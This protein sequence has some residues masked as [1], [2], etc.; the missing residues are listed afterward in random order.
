M[1]YSKLAV[2]L[3]LLFFLV[4]PS[5]LPAYAQEAPEG[6]ITLCYHDVQP[7]E[8]NQDSLDA[9][10][11]TVKELS[12][13]FEWLKNNGY[14]S[15][16]IDDILAA[17][18][19]EKALPKKS[20]LLS[21]D[22]GY[23]SFYELVFPMLKAY[24]FKSLLALQTGWLSTP[25]GK[26]VQYGEKGKMPREHF[27]TWAQIKE[28]ADSG[29]VEIASHS[30]RLHQGHLSTPQG[31]KQPAGASRKYDPKT[32]QYESIAEFK[33]RIKNDL[34]QSSA[35]IQQ[36]TGYKPR[37]IVWPYGHYT[38]AGSQAAKEAGF[39]I[40]ASLSVPSDDTTI[41]RFLIYSG[42]NL[43]EVID[44]MEKGLEWGHSGRKG[45]TFQ[46]N[47]K[48][49]FSPRYRLQRVV[50]VD[51]DM[52][53]DPDPQQQYNNIS[54]LF[55]R[56]KASGCNVVYLQAY[57]DPDGD[58]VAD[59]LYFPNRH[60]PMRADLFN[61]LAWQI[62]S[63]F[64]RDIH[65]YAWMPV[66]GFTI[67]DRPMVE[68]V[69]ADKAG[70]T[71]PRLS[72]FDSTNRQII[73]EIYE[74]LASHSIITGVLF[75]DDAILGDYEDISAPGRAWLKSQNL[76]ENIDDIHKDPRLMERFS[77]GKTKALIDFTAELQKAMEK[78]SP[79]LKS[80]RNIYAQVVLQPESE[81]WYAQNF[82]DFIQSYDYT[83]V[84]AMPYMEGASNPDTWLK[85]IAQKVAKHPLGQRKTVFELQAVDWSQ[86]N[87]PSIP[88]KTLARHMDILMLNG[89]PN[90]GYYP[91]NPIK[92]TP[93]VN[94]IVKSFSL[95]SNPFILE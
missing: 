4:A 52:V 95:N 15:I 86:P 67:P 59:S 90:Y 78:W 16:G 81:Q 22:D 29:L 45:P 40:G 9:M 73:K 58:G 94:T 41:S 68:A 82:D 18:S 87:S 44:S 23:T 56:L 36:H 26:H 5:P 10:P 25:Q 39:S 11:V 51:I 74:D 27:L 24:N 33:L 19:G 2:I 71:Y 35:L 63:R 37:V 93:E 30:H 49:L 70:S 43:P 1:Y 46:T 62:K 75:H 77:R 21:F 34:A 32:G 50:H 72:P 65:V 69:S 91:E 7:A 66:L 55:D 80:A 31:V 61:Y 53:Y 14:T 92:G 20:V 12:D 47:T 6:F 48:S 85:N 28:M 57:A 79:P 54:A 88:G 8:A 42:V 64:G 60:L 84:M 76:P 89:I 38:Q 83:A 13:H 17:R 3:Y